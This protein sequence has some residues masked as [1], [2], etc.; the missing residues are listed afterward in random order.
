MSL[1]KIF[2]VGIIGIVCFVGIYFIYNHYFSLKSK[3]AHYV[4]EYVDSN[5]FSGAV[6]VAKDDNILLAKGY[7]LANYELNVHN[8]CEIKFRLGSITKQFTALAIMQLQE[9]GLLNVTDPISKFIPDYPRGK[10]ITIHNLLAH[11]SGI[12]NI[13]AFPEYEKKKIKHHTLEQLIS[14]FKN[15]SLEFSPGEKYAYSNSNYILLTYLIE[16]A[17]GQTYDEFLRKNIFIPLNMKNTVCDDYRRI[18]KNRASGYSMQDD[19]LVNASY[20][21]MSFP[22]GAGALC[23]TINDLY[24]WDQAL[25]TQKLLSQKSLDAIFTPFKGNYGYG[26]FIESSPHGKV[27][28]HGGAIDGFVTSI[29]RLV[30]HKICI[31]V[32]SNFVFAPVDKIAS[33]LAR[34]TFSE[35]PQYRSRNPV[36]I[37]INPLIYDQYMG[38]YKSE[39]PSLTFVV[40]KKDNKLRIKLIEENEEYEVSPETESKFFLKNLDVQFSFIKDKGK[41]TTLI[42]HEGTKNLPCKKVE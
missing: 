33:D 1:S 23:S 37:S 14:R 10:E 32:L 6:L 15:K 9:K 41:V 24:L 18:I 25:Y 4:Q 30:D 26:W 39:K 31:I 8:T 21:D 17:S 35:N 19:T 11:T 22:A 40:T 5:L 2:I 42:L 13:T 7:N 34:I 20:I 29:Y 12:P 38:T 16:K 3:L 36:E 28:T 27:I